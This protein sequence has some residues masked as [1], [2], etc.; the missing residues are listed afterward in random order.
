MLPLSYSWNENTQIIGV[1]TVSFLPFY[2][3]WA[4]H[5]RAFLPACVIPYQVS[6]QRSTISTY[7]VVEEKQSTEQA[8]QICCEQGE[9]DWRG[10]GFLYD[11]WHEAVE[12]K[13]A[14]TE[15]DIEQ[16]CGERKER[17]HHSLLQGLCIH[18]GWKTGSHL[19]FIQGSFSFTL[20]TDVYYWVMHN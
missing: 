8:V 18:S 12:T 19:P 10:T 14:G 5:K 9:V 7:L 17:W 16:A 20:L 1:N 15:A 11:D 3:Q 13:H 6:S 2:T 4:C